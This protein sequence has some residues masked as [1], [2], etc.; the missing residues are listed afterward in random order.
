MGTLGTLVLLLVAGAGWGDRLAGQATPG[1]R[2]TL[3]FVAGLL[4]LHLAGLA[5]A[6]LGLPF[7]VGTAGVA[8]VLQAAAV[9][10]C[11]RG[12]AAS[13]SVDRRAETRGWGTGLSLVPI[14]V[15]G[16]LGIRGEVA[17]SDYVFH[18]GAKARHLFVGGRL[19]FEW[20][21]RV[22]NRHLHADYPALLPHLYAFTARLRGDWLDAE[23]F[24]WSTVFFLG[25][26]IAVGESFAGGRSPGDLG[27]GWIA[28]LGFAVGTFAVAHR[29]AG[30]ADWILAFVAAA[31]LGD[32]GRRGDPAGDLRLGA[33]AGL[34]AASKAEG[35][36]LALLLIVARS[37]IP[38][39]GGRARRW[40]ELAG[41]TLAVIVPWR[42]LVHVHGLGGS[43]SLGVPDLARWPDVVHGLLRT[44]ALESWWGFGGVL[45]LLPAVFLR[46]PLRLAAA[47]LAGQA[48]CYVLVYLS[49]PVDTRWLVQTSAA[50]LAFHLLPACWVLLGLALQSYV[51]DSASEETAR[52]DGPDP[53]IP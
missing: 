10:V 30:S 4:H 42:W 15:F 27:E 49:A 24:S 41:P 39:P 37:R 51:D 31:A 14:T 48:A 7:T 13:R 45:L 5:L 35:A 38:A 22:W 25:V 6:V 2:W 40:L 32:L 11:L 21:G 44:P 47:V 9:R 20:L 8:V 52:G 29:M 12:D 18:W 34:A 1:F 3:F 28:I 23:M 36:L 16:A 17:M 26:V 33:L 50:R 53:A 46:P 43:R 19:D